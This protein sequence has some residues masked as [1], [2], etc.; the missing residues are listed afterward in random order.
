MKFFLSGFSFTDTDDSHDNRGREGTIF[1]SILPLPPAQKHSDIYF[2]T[3][4]VRWISHVFNRT[5]CIY[6]AGTRWDLP[7]YRIIIWLIDD[8]IMIFVCLLVDLIQGFC[9]S[10][11]TLETGG[12]ELAST[13]IFVLK[14][15]RLT[16][17]ASQMNLSQRTVFCQ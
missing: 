11:L 14:A 13:V 6:Q 12:L 16:K 1:Y 2:A 17:C 10:H 5:A 7:P 15:N 4:R 8:A 3:L 9:Y